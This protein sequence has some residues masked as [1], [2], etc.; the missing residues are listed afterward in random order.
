MKAFKLLIAMIIIFSC[1]TGLALTEE[2]KKKVIGFIPMTMGNEYFLIMVNAARSEAKRQNVELLVKYGGITH[3]N[4]NQQIKIV[5][6]MIAQEVDAICIVPSST[7]V[8]RAIEKAQQAKIPIINIDTRI[9]PEFIKKY[10]VATIPYIGTNN[11]T[12]AKKGGE[13]SINTL[14]ISGKK[15][16]ILIGISNHQN[17][18]DRWNGFKDAVFEKVF[19]V[20]ERPANWEFDEAYYRFKEILQN[21][22]DLTFVFACND[23]MA[24]GAIKAIKE[25]ERKNITV[26]GY[27]G[28]TSALDA[29]ENRT[30][31]ATVAQ[32]PAEMGIKGVQ[33]ALELIKG[34]QVP[35]IT[36]TETK[37][38]D[39]SN[40]SKFKAYLNQY[41]EPFSEIVR[42]NQ[43]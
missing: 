41:T 31:A 21:N 28:T 27:D 1:M 11:Y 7:G 6:D 12:G 25:T 30:M 22:L 2:A 18:K 16:A 15:A 37:I 35:E 10:E 24:L 14:G 13:Y 34:N 39:S 33:M 9:D 43:K 8:F 36:Y 19:I 3:K 32:L 38:I 29:I 4:L 23:N 17:A 26:M 20:A 42:I 5:E 40:V